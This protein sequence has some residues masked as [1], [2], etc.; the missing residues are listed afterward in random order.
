M[1][2]LMSE[3]L[4]WVT[5]YAA[6]SYIAGLETKD[7]IRVSKLVAEKG[8]SST[9]CPW[10]GPHDAPESVAA[11]YKEALNS[12]KVEKLDC[13]LS[14]KVP[15]LAYDIN[16]LTELVIIARE[17]E[18]RL[19]FD[20]LAPD[21]ATASIALLQETVKIY[22][23]VGYTLPSRWRRSIVDADKIV[24]LGIPVRL[25]KGQWPDPLAPN[26]DAESNFLDLVDVLAGRASRVAIATH[27]TRLARESLLR[28]KRAGTYCELEQLYGLPMR[29]SVASAAWRPASLTA[30]QSSQARP[31]R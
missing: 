17:H 30:T 25:V 6:S 14:I 24:D 13:Y 5:R 8:F 9:I 27:D 15:S 20:S 2:T 31:S 11:S 4:R 28:L 1:R 19:H 7:A 21:T 3:I 23:N 29:D 26:I 18:I 22:H 16:L 12:I 10:D